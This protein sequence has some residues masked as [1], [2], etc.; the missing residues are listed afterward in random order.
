V[1]LLRLERPGWTAGPGDDWHWADDVPAAAAA[2]V[3]AGLGRRALLALGRQDVAAFAGVG[4][5]WFLLR[6]VDA[7]EPPLPARHEVLLARGPFRLAG[8]LALVDRHAIDVVVT[9]DSGGEGASAK[10][11]AARRRGLPVLVV[12]RPPRPDG[13]AVATV[14][15]A[16]R[17][18]GD[19]LREAVG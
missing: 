13:P 18:T 5:V 7:P 9:R 8:E 15:E 14:G 2:A 16:L 6:S 1:P 3:V 17:W 11:A 10:L 4:D 19:R 12:R